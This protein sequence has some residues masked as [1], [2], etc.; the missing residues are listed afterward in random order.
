MLANIYATLY[1][2]SGII[3]PLNLEFAQ[4]VATFYFNEF[5]TIAAMANAF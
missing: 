3:Q 1:T 2:M 5:S 4:I